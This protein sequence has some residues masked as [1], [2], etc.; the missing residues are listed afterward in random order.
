MDTPIKSSKEVIFR[1]VHCKTQIHPYHVDPMN[2]LQY[3]GDNV[4][5]GAAHTLERCRDAVKTRSHVAEQKLVKASAALRE[6]FDGPPQVWLDWY[7]RHK[8]IITELDP[9]V[10]E[11][12]ESI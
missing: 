5:A 7:N 3:E 4:S 9:D 1:C 12:Y 10:E 2:G 11:E 6:I 8:D